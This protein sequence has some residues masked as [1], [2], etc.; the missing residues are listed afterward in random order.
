MLY[1]SGVNWATS[2][3]LN[4]NLGAHKSPFFVQLLL[5]S[6]DVASNGISVPRLWG[7]PNEI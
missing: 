7:N 6:V 1:G 3:E 2:K 4:G 5:S